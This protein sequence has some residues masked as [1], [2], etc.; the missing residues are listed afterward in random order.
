MGLCDDINL[1]FQKH[2]FRDLYTQHIWQYPTSIILKTM[3]LVIEDTL[4]VYQQ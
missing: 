2:V 1:V 4:F 3:H